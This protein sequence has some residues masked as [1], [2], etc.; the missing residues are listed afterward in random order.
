MATETTPRLSN[1]SDRHSE[2][3]VEA[4]LVIVTLGIAALLYNTE[5]MKMVTLNLFF[6]PV[7]LAG[8]FLGRYRAGILALFSVVLATIVIAQDLSGFVR[9]ES[10][11]M[12]GLAITVWG[13]VLGL[14][15]ILVGTLCDERMAKSV[16]AHEA[17]VGV[18][19]VLSRYLQAANPHLESR[20]KRVATLCE[21]VAKKMRLSNKEIDDIRVAALL[22]DMENIEITAR[23]IKKAVGHLNNTAEEQ[24]TFHGSE[25]VQSLGPVLTGAFP[26]L[27][28][29]TKSTEADLLSSDVPF[30]ARVIRTVRAY[31]ELADDPW[32][33]GDIKPHEIVEHLRNDNDQAFHPAVLHALETVVATSSPSDS[34]VGTQV[35]ESSGA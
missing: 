26:I 11:V 30:G 2:R 6:L 31:L 12:V 14:T 24:R 25:L 17:H 32:E 19:E 10:P 3:A 13:A 18:I 23:V 35:V 34:A 27:L 20:A 9:V 16:E 7:V 28:N 4:M 29:Q 5:S 8:F 22:M 15:A 21:R 33:T 1:A